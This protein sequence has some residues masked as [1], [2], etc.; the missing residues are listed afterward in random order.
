MPRFQ[1]KSENIVGFTAENAGPGERVKALTKFPLITS[2]DPFFYVLMTQI[3]KVFLNKIPFPPDHIY[4]FIILLHNDYTADLFIN[5][6]SE[7]YKVKVNRSI[8]KGQPVYTKDIED[9]AELRFVNVEIKSNDA[10]LYCTKIG[11][12][13][14]LF[15]DFTREVNLDDLSKELGK[16]VKKLH[17]ERD[18][19]ATDLE[20]QEIE[21]E[22]SKAALIITE[23][24]TDWKHL[25]K[26]QGGLKIGLSIK[27]DEYESDRG[28]AD[29]LKMCEHFSRIPDH[30]KIIFVFDQDNPQIIQELNRRTKGE[31]RYQDWGNNTFSFY[32][33]K[34]SHRGKYNNISIEFYYTDD[35]IHTIDLETGKQL[36]FSNE[37]EERGT[38]SLTRKKYTSKFV[39]LDRPKNDEEFDKKIYS[40]DTDTIEDERGNPVAHSKEVFANNILNDKP[41]FNNF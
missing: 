35:E 10:L 4:R 30:P 29:I 12:K 28:D 1:I 7:I 18:V 21:R 6:F 17:F 24:K 23:G 34:P 38:K 37:V 2:D 15:F 33:P 31:N 26:A 40:Q 5:D 11:W 22:K 16:L 3:T 9:I 27:F 41:L 32:I 25:K 14:G 19:S 36:L 8:E 13:F 20:L 39:K